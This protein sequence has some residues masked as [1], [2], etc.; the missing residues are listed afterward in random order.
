M[1]ER[2]RGEGGEEEAE[3]KNKNVFSTLGNGN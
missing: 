3:K 2:L 1:E